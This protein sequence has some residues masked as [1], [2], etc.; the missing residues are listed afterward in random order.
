VSVVIG[1]ETVEIM[2][3]GH[4]VRHI[5]LSPWGRNQAG[6]LVSAITAA[7]GHRREWSLR[8][9][10]MELADV[11]ALEAELDAVGSVVVSGALIDASNPITCYAS[12]VQ[13]EQNNTTWARLTFDLFED[14]WTFGGYGYPIEASSTGFEVGL[15]DDD[16]LRFRDL[17]SGTM[18]VHVSGTMVARLSTIGRFTPEAE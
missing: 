15:T 8:L 4:S 2:E 13:R 12:N 11:V 7:R 18:D 10:L 1:A 3:G 14:D 9:P 5:P 6:V 16:S 17:G